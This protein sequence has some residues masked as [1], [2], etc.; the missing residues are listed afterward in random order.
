[1]KKVLA[2]RIAGLSCLYFLL[3]ACSPN[4]SNSL[5]SDQ[6]ADLSSHSV[7]KTAKVDELYVKSYS[8]SIA[9]ASGLTKA[10]VSGECYTSTFPSHKIVAIENGTLLDFMDLNPASDVNAK[11]ALCING[12]FN[13]S[14]NAGAL[15]G[16][17]HSIRLVMQAYDNNN[18]LVTND[19][20]GV[21]TLTLTK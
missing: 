20:Q 7:D 14:I 5:L 12:K 15:A 1:M 18:Q 4:Q 6:K 19:V 17:I 8:P 9:L 10:E 11:Q 13:L 16:G 2:L 21:S 3:A